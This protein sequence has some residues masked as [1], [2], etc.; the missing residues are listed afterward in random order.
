M[1]DEKKKYFCMECGVKITKRQ[2][3]SVAVCET[4]VYK[5]PHKRDKRSIAGGRKR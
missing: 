1:K 3:D 4:C 2:W 5:S